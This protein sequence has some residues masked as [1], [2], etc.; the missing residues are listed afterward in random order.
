M[1]YAPDAFNGMCIRATVY[2]KS[3][4]LHPLITIFAVF[5]GGILWGIAGIIMALPLSIILITTYK[6]FGQD[7]TSKVGAMKGTKK[8]A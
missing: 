8:K 3:N 5:A 4:E 6:F 2:G 1:D 7:I